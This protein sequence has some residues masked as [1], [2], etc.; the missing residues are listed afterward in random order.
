M[1]DLKPVFLKKVKAILASNV[2]EFDVMVYG[3]RAGGAAKKYSYLDLVVMSD[4]PLT[5]ARLE[6]IEA[7]FTAAS[8]PFRVETICWAATGP[9]FRKEIKKTGVLIQTSPKK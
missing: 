7:A 2:P 1:I 8:F 5:A 4:K 9:S 6:K 3:H